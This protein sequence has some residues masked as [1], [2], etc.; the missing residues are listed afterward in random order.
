MDY[1]FDLEDTN[2]VD[3][4]TQEIIEFWYTRWLEKRLTTVDIEERLKS[5][6]LSDL[7]LGNI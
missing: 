7:L 1:G 6:K 3:E 5:F 2:D 4:K